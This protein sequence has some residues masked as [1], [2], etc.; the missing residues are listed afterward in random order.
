MVHAPTIPVLLGLFIVR[1]AGADWHCDTDWDLVQLFDHGAF[2]ST[3]EGRDSQYCQV[4]CDAGYLATKS[5]Y[6]EYPDLHLNAYWCHCLS[7]TECTWG[8]AT[9]DLGCQA[10]ECLSDQ[11]VPDATHCKHRQIGEKCEVECNAGYYAANG[12]L[13]QYTCAATGEWEGG[14]LTCAKTP[15]FCRGLLPTG[16]HAKFDPKSC[17]G[18]VD[19]QCKAECELGFE[20]AGGGA[21]VYTCG[22]DGQWRAAVSPPLRCEPRCQNTVPADHAFFTPCERTPGSTCEARCGSGYSGKGEPVYTCGNNGQWA[23]GKLTCTLTGC[24]DKLPPVTEHAQAC[25]SA[26]L[27]GKCTPDCAPG[28]TPGDATPYNCTRVHDGKPA[29]W[30]GGNLSCTISPDWCAGAL[31]SLV[32]ENINVSHCAQTVGTE[33][34][35]RCT[36][37]SYPIMGTD[38]STYTCSSDSRDSSSRDPQWLPKTPSDLLVCKKK[39]PVEVPSLHPDRARFQ[40]CEGLPGSKCKAECMSRF[41]QRSGDN[42][43]ECQNGEWKGAKLLCV[44]PCKP[45]TIPALYN[46][47]TNT[48]TR[49]AI[50]CAPCPDG[51]FSSEKNDGLQC[52]NCPVP[53][54]QKTLC[55]RCPEGQGPNPDNTV[56]QVC[57]DLNKNLVSQH[58]VCQAERDVSNEI[59]DLWDKS[60]TLDKVLAIAGLVLVIALLLFCCSRKLVEDTENRFYYIVNLSTAIVALVFLFVNLELSSDEWG[61]ERACAATTAATWLPVP[62]IIRRYESSLAGLKDPRSDP[63]LGEDRTWTG[64]FGLLLF[65]YGLADIVIDT[66]FCVKLLLCG[67]TVLFV[68]GTATMILTTLMTWYLGCRTLRSIVDHDQR[69]GKPAAAWLSNHELAGPIV[70]LASSSRLNSMAILR[71]KIGKWKILD[72]DDSDNQRYFHFM[73]NSGMFHYLVEDI[74]HAMTSLAVISAGHTMGCGEDPT[75]AKLSLLFS[76][77]SILVGIISKTIQQLTMAIIDDPTTPSHPLLPPPDGARKTM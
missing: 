51:K 60:D 77:G 46:A 1:V 20:P 30:I 26:A 10:T 72:F 31:P 14:S 25:P 33:C 67:Q 18:T 65:F 5:W 17:E 12:G 36:N 66:W 39:C 76:L 68:C 48:S 71:L 42:D 28:Y 63:R 73:R 38:H 62:Y 45:G 74:P 9:R 56:C 55:E 7:A 16:Q 32:S 59:R 41:V 34:N 44:L 57:G 11:P 35:A 4:E 8:D 37:G 69:H 61:W 70:V 75:I 40:T 3:C 49:D 24:G 47:S 2:L 29:E 22:A 21:N 54:A 53:N 23:G 6:L 43:F 13:G 64:P 50:H 19:E 27:N 58:G 52:E 15:R